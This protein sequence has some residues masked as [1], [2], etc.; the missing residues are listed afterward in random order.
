MAARDLSHTKANDA[1][2]GGWV[3]DAG[4][5]GDWECIC[6]AH[7]DRIG[8]MKSTKRMA[9]AGGWIYQVTTEGPKGYAEAVCFVPSPS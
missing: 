1:R 4:D 7:H 2:K 9:V 6:K 8:M 5:P 3:I